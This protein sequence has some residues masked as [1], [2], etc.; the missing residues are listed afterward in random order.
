VRSLARLNR[1]SGSLPVP[2]TERGNRLS[3]GMGVGY[4]LDHHRFCA[5]LFWWSPGPHSA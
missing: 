5:L 1:A 3:A 2:K 4:G